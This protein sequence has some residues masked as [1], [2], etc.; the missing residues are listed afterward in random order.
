MPPPTACRPPLPTSL[1]GPPTAH[2]TAKFVQGCSGRRIDSNLNRVWQ[3]KSSDNGKRIRRFP[4]IKRRDVHSEYW[5]AGMRV[6]AMDCL[7]L[8][9][10]FANVSNHVI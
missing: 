7:D 6:K 1:P 9:P 5:L 4:C 8:N 2:Q 10:L 3:L